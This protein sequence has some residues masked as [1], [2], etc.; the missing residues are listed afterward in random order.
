MHGFKEVDW[1]IREASTCRELNIVATN[2]N[3]IKRRK[4]F[5]VNSEQSMLNERQTM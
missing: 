2:R 1:M 3:D 4:R 5:V